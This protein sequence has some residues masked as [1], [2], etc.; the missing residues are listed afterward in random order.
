MNR[1]IS[2]AISMAVLLLGLLQAPAA[3]AVER[4]D[5]FPH[6]ALEIRTHEGRQW[7]NIWIADTE[8]REEQGL[9]FCRQL[10]SDQG[11]L[12][13]QSQPRVMTMW[14]R[15]TLISLDMLFITADG[16]IA[17]IRERAPPE[18]DDII[19]TQTPVKA[20]LEL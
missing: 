9:M 2:A 7:F 15:N 1:T 14:M 10:P 4:L 19:T 8:P 13:P 20:V 5:Q 12:F 16:R 11:M 6:S 3:R 18:S 17:Y